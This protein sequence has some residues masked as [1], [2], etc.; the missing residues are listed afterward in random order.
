MFHRPKGME[1]EPAQSVTEPEEAPV[2]AAARQPES[3]A[4]APHAR[5]QPQTEVRHHPIEKA[6]EEKK[7][8]SN[9]HASY[10]DTQTRPQ[11][12]TPQASLRPS[13]PYGAPGYNAMSYGTAA[14]SS[15]YGTSAQV[16]KSEGR[17]L[18]IGSGIT[19]S[20][21]IEAC[22]VLVIEGTVE[23]ALKGASIL[24]VAETGVFYGAVEIDEC[25]I[26]GRFEGDLTVNGR[27]TIKGSGSIT[28]SIA[29]KELAVEAG[30]TLDGKVTPLIAKGAKKADKPAKEGKSVS[31]RGRA[32]DRDDGNELPFAGSAVA[33]AE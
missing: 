16:Q 26:A 7:M 25:T 12:S 15:P 8:S 5:P 1:T 31:P 6:K 27:L 30:A 33:A 13:A 10:Q 2:V 32:E 28:G 24:E 20:G 9:E 21:E 11:Q 14:S 17:R 3:A 18:V 4:A 22:D 23:A 29:Y 19:M